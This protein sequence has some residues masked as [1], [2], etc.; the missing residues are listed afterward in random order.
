MRDSCLIYSLPLEPCIWNVA[1]TSLYWT[2]YLLLQKERY[3]ICIYLKRSFLPQKKL[4]YH[5][6]AHKMTNFFIYSKRPP[7]TSKKRYQIVNLFKTP[8]LL[9]KKQLLPQEAHKMTKILNLF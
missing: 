7:L 8:L 3:Q 1:H 4:Y 9:Q 2:P 6:G 5:K